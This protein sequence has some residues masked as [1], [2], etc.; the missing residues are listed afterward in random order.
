MID[1][2]TLAIL[3][4]RLT[5]IADEMDATLYRAAFNP[6]IAEAKDACHGLYHAETG[7]TL[8]QGASG[9]PIF[10]GA[11][12]FAVRAVIDKVARDGGLAPGDTFLFNDPYAGGT[13]LNDF[14]LVRPVFRDRTAVLLDGLGRPLARHRRQRARRLQPPRHRELPGGRPHPPGETDHRRA[15]EPR[16]AGHPRRQLP[17]AHL[18]L[19]RPQ[20]PARRARPRRAPA[21][22]VCSTN[23]ATPWWPSR[24]RRLL[25]P[26]R[27]HDARRHP[28]PAGRPPTPSRTCWTMTASPPRDADRGTRPHHRRRHHGD[29]LLPLIAPPTQGPVNISY[30]TTIAACYVALKH[31]FTAVPANA[32]CL[33]PIRFVVPETTMLAATARRAPWRA[34]PRPSCASSASCSAPSPRPTRHARH[35]RPLRHHQR[36]VDGRA[37]HRRLALG[38]VQLLRRRHGRQPRD[39]RP[40][41]RQQPHLHRHHPAR[42]DPGS[43]LPR[44]CSPN[45]R[46]ARILAAPAPIAAAS[47]P[48]T[49]SRCSP[50]QRSPSSASAAPSAPS[51]CVGGGSGALNRFIWQEDD[52]DHSPAAG[53]E[54]HRR[55]PCRRGPPGPAGNAGR[56]RLGSSPAHRDPAL[57]T[58]RDLPLRLRDRRARRTEPQ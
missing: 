44:R 56:R 27:G 3:D 37:P 45:G 8:V 42:R 29:G 18:E 21:S 46:S 48:S 17:R 4:G 47:A 50:T 33:R 14:R 36:A 26:R 49:R 35:R 7:D 16:P 20:R 55:R 39:R 32:G 40:Q 2:V 52:G 19:G 13:H 25:Q 10:V 38:H 15:H 6:I 31:V 30:A 1:P 41:P 9:L 34:I 57:L 54:G 58:A 28:R 43:R 12:A 11:M 53:L 5:Q 22:T 24:L 23:T 51:A